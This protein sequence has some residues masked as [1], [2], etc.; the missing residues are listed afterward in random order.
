[1]WCVIFVNFISQTVLLKVCKHIFENTFFYSTCKILTFQQVFQKLYHLTWL[2]CKSENKI[3]YGWW[4]FKLFEINSNHSPLV[5]WIRLQ[6]NSTTTILTFTVVELVRPP[7]RIL[8][9]PAGLS[10]VIVPVLIPSV[11]V[12]CHVSVVDVV[13]G[14]RVREVG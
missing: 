8:I 10:G 9:A 11:T 5:M 14:V 12:V 1:M 2:Y 4:A 7:V 13:R 3:N 6:Y